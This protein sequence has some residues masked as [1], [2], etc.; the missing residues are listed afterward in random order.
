M[1][2][3]V[4]IKQY[5]SIR[6]LV[7]AAFFLQVF[8][9]H[10]ALPLF[11]GG[12]DFLFFAPWWMYS[13]G[14][15]PMVYDLTWNNGESYFFRD[16]RSD[17]I[18]SQIDTHTLFHLLSTKNLDRIGQDYGA[19]LKDL[20]GCDSLEVHELSGSLYKHIIQKTPLAASNKFPL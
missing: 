15:K 6:S 17:P 5:L 2:H 18:A 13:S 11:N 3:F 4:R 14:P 10:L 20:C 12:R 19:K 8:M 16:H 7:V 9:A 1:N